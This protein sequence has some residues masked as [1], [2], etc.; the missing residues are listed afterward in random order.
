MDEKYLQIREYTGPG[1]SP[2]IDFDVWRVATLRFIDELLPENMG[3]CERHMET[4]EVF[5]LQQGQAV[6]FIGEG[7]PNVTK[8]TAFKMEPFKMYNVRQ[9]AWH[10]ICMSRDANVLLVENRNTAR[11]NS[12]YC[13]LGPELRRQI[14]ETAGKELPPF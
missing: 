12:Q 2:V 9:A 7:E 13:Q 8:L 4:D 10:T 6:L 5:V 11:E 1:Y 3:Q 14:V